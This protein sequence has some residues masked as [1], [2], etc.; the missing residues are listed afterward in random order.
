MERVKL[1][2]VIRTWQ[3]EGP[4][5]G[6]GMVILRFKYCN[7]SC[8]WCDTRV[9][10]RILPE[11]EY[12]IPMIQE[13]ITE[14]KCGLMITGG[15][16][17]I[18][19][20][21]NECLYLLN[22]LAYPLANVESN[23]FKL[24]ELILQTDKTKNIKFIY[25]P[26]IFDSKDCTKALEKARTLLSKK[27]VILKLVYEDNAYINSFCKDLSSLISSDKNIDDPTSK[28]WLMPEGSTRQDLLRNAPA[29]FDAAEHFKF[30]FTS[31]THIMYSFV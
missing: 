21:F 12:S 30:N 6:R 2:E 20:H 8:K 31:R 23:G 16:P 19:R 15:E 10:M 18:E 11:G 9:K 17:T 7:L 22:T 28:V 24:E 4:D 27:N 5:T 3:G 13:M 25:S 14:N 26:K 1:I 29:V